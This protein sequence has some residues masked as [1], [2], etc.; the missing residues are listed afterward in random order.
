MMR[1][2]WIYLGHLLGGLR[3]RATRRVRIN[4]L[5]SDRV[6]EVHELGAE[7]V[8]YV[9]IVIRHGRRGD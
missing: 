1:F 3:V 7:R 9:V 8:L 5:A 2:M 4:L 6:Q